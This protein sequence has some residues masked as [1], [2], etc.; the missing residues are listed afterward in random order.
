MKNISIICAN[1]NS[2]FETI[3]LRSALEYFGYVPTVHWIGSVEQFTELITGKTSL[4]ELVVLSCHGT[5]E[6]F[7]GTDNVV[8]PLN[9]LT[10]NLPDATVL[11]LGCAT[12]TEAFAKVFINGGVKNYIAPPSYPE[13]NSALMFALMFLWQLHE[14]GDLT[15][16][17]KEAV[18]ILKDS[19][20]QFHFYQKSKNKI[21]VDGSREILS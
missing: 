18:A 5:A 9:K 19:D 13:G 14:K 3:A 2:T 16:A 11:S 12:G 20:D 6:G 1:E 8:I 21:L 4:A 10:V 15:K 17:W 7:H